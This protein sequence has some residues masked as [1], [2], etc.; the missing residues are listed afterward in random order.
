MVYSPKLTFIANDNNTTDVGFSPSET[1]CFGSLEFTV[2][3][4][5]NMSLSP[6]AQDLGAIFIGMV[7]SESPSLHIILRESFDEGNVASGGGGSSGFPGPRACNVV[8]PT[9]PIATTPLLKNTLA[10]LTIPTTQLWTATPQLGIGL[11]PK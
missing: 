8:T 2:D 6:E 7:H 5:S 4:F 9:I 1:I 10:L 3:R 11:L